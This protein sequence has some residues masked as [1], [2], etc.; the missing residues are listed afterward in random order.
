MVRRIL[1]AATLSIGLFCAPATMTVADVADTDRP[2]VI[3]HRGASGYLPEHSLE[4]YKLGIEQG[5]DFIEPDLVMTKDGILVARHD[6]YLSTT[7]NVASHP[8]FA[9]RKRTIGEHNDWFA[10]DF[11]LAELKTLRVR[12]AFKGRDKSFDDLLD[13]VTLD[14]IT[15]LVLDY[16]TKGKTVGLHIEMK[17]PE[18]FKTTLQP[19]LAAMLAGKLAALRTA[20]IPLYFQCFD[21]DFVREIAPLTETPVV[22]LVGGKANPETGWIDLDVKLEDYYGS[23]DGFG[24][25]KAL[26]FDQNMKP[27][28]IVDK[29]HTAEKLVHVWTV[30]AD[31]L[32][33]GFQSMDQELKLLLDNGVDGFFTDFPSTAVKFRNAYAGAEKE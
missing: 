26:L 32:P 13:I 24:L 7:T 11:T 2:I 17:R 6:I 23:A 10:M 31:A 1:T 29:L 27:S 25:N 28:G 19:D 9:D 15:A 14:E 21:G 16:K 8:E 33:K 22:L 3:A 30:R 5:A 4:A 18:L 20:G 12:Q